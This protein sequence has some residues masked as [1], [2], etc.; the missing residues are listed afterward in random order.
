MKQKTNSTALAVE[1]VCKLINVSR[2]HIH[3]L[4]IS[5]N[6]SELRYACSPLIQTYRFVTGSPRFRKRASRSRHRPSACHSG[7][8]FPAPSRGAQRPSHR[9]RFEPQATLVGRGSI[10]GKPVCPTR[11]TSPS[12]II[13]SIVENGESSREI[14]SL[15]SRMS[16]FSL[17]RSRGVCVPD[18]EGRSLAPSTPWRLRLEVI[19]QIAQPHL[20]IQVRLEFPHLVTDEAEGVVQCHPLKI[21]R[22]G[23]QVVTQAIELGKQFLGLHGNPSI[24]RDALVRTSAARW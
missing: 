4:H 23:L 15:Q 22:V 19:R 9:A 5:Q 7:L 20:L 14:R 2:L 11:W 18:A 24:H 13:K 16:R 6:P 1:F 21:R 10:R 17:V 8:D 3:G 12:P